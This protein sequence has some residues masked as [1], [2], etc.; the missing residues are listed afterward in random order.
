M[1]DA[2]Q[3]GPGNA[4][5]QTDRLRLDRLSLADGALTPVSQLPSASVVGLAFDRSGRLWLGA[6]PQLEEQLRGG[7]EH[8]LE[9]SRVSLARHDEGKLRLGR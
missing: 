6:G 5:A 1:S 2:G 8:P 4:V 7:I 3:H 9:V